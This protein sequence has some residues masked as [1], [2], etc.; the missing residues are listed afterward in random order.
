MKKF[1]IE[2]SEVVV[3]KTL[4]EAKSRD[5]ASEKFWEEYSDLTPADIKNAT[6]TFIAESQQ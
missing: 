1:Y 5:E 6:I 2:A 4:V 3:Y